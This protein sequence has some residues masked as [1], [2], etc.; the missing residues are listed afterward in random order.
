MIPMKID[1]LKPQSQKVAIFIVNYNMPERADNLY[2]YLRSHVKYPIDIY[3][4]DNGSDLTNPSQYTNVWIEK[5]IQTTGGWLKGLK[6]SDRKLYRYFA[7]MFLIT[8]TEFVKESK[9]PISSMIKCLQTNK[10]AV[11]VHP[12]LTQD[13]TTYWE[14]LKNRKQKGFRKTW[15]ID[16]IASLYKADW[17][18]S[19]GR[20]DKDL[21]YAHGIDLETG[22]IARKQGK[23]IWIDE[24]IQVR[25][26]SNIGYSMDRMNMSAEDRNKLAWE[27]TNEVM[28]RKYGPTW[29][30]ILTKDYIDNDML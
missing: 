11:G 10:N 4:I 2:K 15:F 26:I 22:Y 13:S 1:N 23:T 24:N 18:N 16:N 20:F 27:N 12:S 6:I 3:L 19:I 8:S 29:N 5:N 14:H 25:K 30:T 9:D 28:T 21:I 17:F 7:Y